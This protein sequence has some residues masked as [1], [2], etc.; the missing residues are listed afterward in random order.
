MALTIRQVVDLSRPPAA[1]PRVPAWKT[2]V[3]D[4]SAFNN[5]H[6]SRSARWSVNASAP[7]GTRH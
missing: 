3:N 4:K 1:P 7:G 5:V 6:E 2:I